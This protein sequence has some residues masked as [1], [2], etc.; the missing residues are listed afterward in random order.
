MAL[1]NF[2]AMDGSNIFHYLVY[3]FNMLVNFYNTYQKIIDQIED[4]DD[5]KKKQELYLMI[6]VAN[7]EGFSPFDFAFQQSSKFID[8]FLKMLTEVPDYMLSK[9]VFKRPKAF[10][11]LMMLELVSFNTFLDRCLY[12]TISMQKS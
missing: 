12:K 2:R 10:K 7:N 3:N 4:S 9:F 6:L 11:K 8:M 5:K 1:I